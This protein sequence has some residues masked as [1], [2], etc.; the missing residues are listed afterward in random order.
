MPGPRSTPAED[1]GGGGGLRAA[2]E[3]VMR[4][5]TAPMLQ[6]TPEMPPS[7]NGNERIEN[8]TLHSFLTGLKQGCRYYLDR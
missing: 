4:S 2:D 5:N 1:G 3:T 7:F 6:K 8:N